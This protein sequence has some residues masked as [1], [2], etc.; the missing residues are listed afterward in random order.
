VSKPISEAQMPA[1][2]FGNGK[3]DTPDRCASESFS[4]ASHKRAGGA[5]LQRPSSESLLGS[6]RCS[7]TAQS[8]AR[9]L[10]AGDPFNIM[11]HAKARLVAQ[12]MSVEGRH[13]PNPR[14]FENYLNGLSVDALTKRRD[15]L[16]R[17]GGRRG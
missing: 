10:R 11:A 7:S 4:T 3:N 6:E 8:P 5:E 17:T 1:G 12:I 16:L 13:T 9:P 14:G 15:E 2:K